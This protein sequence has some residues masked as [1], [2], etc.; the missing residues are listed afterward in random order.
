MG[1]PEVLECSGQG[2]TGQGTGLCLLGY[3][4]CHKGTQQQITALV[5][6]EGTHGGFSASRVG[7]I[8]CASPGCTGS[9]GGGPNPRETPVEFDT[10]ETSLG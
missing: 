10:A 3:H 5:D 4:R 7:W 2:S 8:L 9:T 1:I 6:T